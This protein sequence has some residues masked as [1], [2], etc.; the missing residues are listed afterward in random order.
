[1]YKHHDKYSNAHMLCAA[2]VCNGD[3]KTKEKKVRYK[4]YTARCLGR[5]L[6]DARTAVTCVSSRPISHMEISLAI[7][8]TRYRRVEAI[9]P[10][11][12]EDR[13]RNSTSTAVSPPATAH[14]LDRSNV[15]F[16]LE[17]ASTLIACR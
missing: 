4:F 13:R 11:N 15:E 12:R 16:Q 14:D 9:L 2:I 7:A 17:M 8:D 5:T 3:G 1:M 10:D 6:R